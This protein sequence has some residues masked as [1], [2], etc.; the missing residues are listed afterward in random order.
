MNG[1][2]AGGQMPEFIDRAKHAKDWP[3]DTIPP[4]EKPSFTRDWSLP[5]GPF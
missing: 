5:K 1:N 4:K 3:K 2:E